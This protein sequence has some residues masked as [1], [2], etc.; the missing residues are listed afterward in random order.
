V[1]VPQS[2]LEA[3]HVAQG[4]LR[5]HDAFTAALVAAAAGAVAMAAVAM[6]GAAVVGIAPSSPL[7]LIGESFV[8]PEALAGG[9]K[10]A[11]GVLVH[12][13]TSLAFALL[14]V[15]VVPRDYRAGSA[16]G[17]GV[18]FAMFGLMFMMSVVV[19]WA[20]P[21]FRSGMQE[22]GGTWVI[23]HAV[24]G[25]AL[26]TTPALRRHLARENTVEP[27]PAGLPPRAQPVAPPRAS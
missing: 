26:G 8:G 20:N 18:G 25:L 15:G 9:G 11:Y 24:F 7:A 5:R 17:V 13:V 16:L 2:V 22:I 21:G 6:V 3:N 23:A 4:A 27:V 10:V 14:F 1:A 19:P 12:V